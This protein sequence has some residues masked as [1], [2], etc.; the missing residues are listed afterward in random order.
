MTDAQLAAILHSLREG[1]A[2]VLGARLHRVLL[3]GS[4]ARGEARD[5]SDID[6]L[7]VVDGPVDYSL[8]MR[9]TSDLVASLSLQ[10]DVVISR[11]FVSR[12]Q[13]ENEQTPFLQTIR[14]EHVP[15]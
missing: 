9:Q 10:H 6:V 15:V 12:G 2:R 13:F 1:L 14:R 3:Y 8:L 7:V 5:D 11:V 4:R